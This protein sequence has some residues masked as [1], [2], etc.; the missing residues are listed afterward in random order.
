MRSIEEWIS[1]H[2]DQAIPDRVKLRIFEREQR[3]CQICGGD[4]RPGDGVD[5][6]HVPALADGGEHRE[7]RIFPVHRKCHRLTTAKEA[8]ER[9]ETRT[10]IKKHYGIAKPKGRP[11]AGTRAS[12]LRKKFNGTVERR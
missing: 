8:L 9:A 3:K 2:D 11:M 12:G 1:K 4:I 6:H 7:S 5:Y 10:T